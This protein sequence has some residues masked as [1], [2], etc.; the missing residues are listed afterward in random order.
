MSEKI[1]ISFKSKYKGKFRDILSEKIRSFFGV[2]STSLIIFLAGFYVAFCEGTSSSIDRFTSI[3]F[4][5]A[6]IICIPLAFIIPL[7]KWKNKG[8]SGDV[9][10]EIFT[11]EKRYA[12]HATKKGVPFY[13]ENSIHFLRIY[14]HT[15]TFG[16]DSKMPYRIP[17]KCLDAQQLQDIKDFYSTFQKAKNK[18]KK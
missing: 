9:F 6:A 11:K 3:G 10:I 14:K 18:K 17:K 8:F 12:I 7:F 1:S 4:F 15:I 13:E 16:W 2:L 5:V